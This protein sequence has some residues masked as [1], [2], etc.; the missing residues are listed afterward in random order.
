MRVRHAKCLANKHDKLLSIMSH[1]KV[2]N[3]HSVT[4]ALDYKFH[5]DENPTGFGLLIRL[6]R[7]VV[8]FSNPELHPNRLMPSFLSL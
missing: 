2:G 6:R 3:L 5:V 7:A 8:G 1:I 4:L